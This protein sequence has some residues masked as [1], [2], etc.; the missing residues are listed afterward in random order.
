MRAGSRS[1]RP[2]QMSPRPARAMLLTSKPAASPSHSGA[3]QRLAAKPCPHSPRTSRLRAEAAR[4]VDQAPAIVAAAASSASEQAVVGEVEEVARQR[5]AYAGH[6]EDR[7]RPRADGQREELGLARVDD[8]EELGAVARRAA[9]AP[10][11]IVQ[12]GAAARPRATRS[13]SSPVAGLNR[14]VVAGVHR[15]VDGGLQVRRHQV[16]CGERAARRAHERRHVDPDDAVGRAAAA[17]RA[18]AEQHVDPLGD[19][20]GIDRACAAPAREHPRE[21]RHLVPERLG[22]EVHLVG[23]AVARVVVHQRVVATRRAEPAVQAGIEVH[24]VVAPQQ[25]CERLARAQDG[26]GIE[27]L[28]PAAMRVA[29]RRRRGRRCRDVDA[30]AHDRLPCHAE[31]T[32]P[33]RP[34][35][36]PNSPRARKKKTQWRILPSGA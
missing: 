2:S 18:A 12:L 33:R 9:G 25:A 34:R 23:R 32:M 20:A 7:P 4:G 15:R 22:H 26:R 35:R 16:G 19:R 6:V 31:R 21:R 13:S 24:G 3:S 14:H 11:R 10:C 29:G 36:A 27:R 1:R 17:H 8:V 30:G 28:E 5:P